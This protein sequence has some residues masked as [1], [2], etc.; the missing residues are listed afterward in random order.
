MEPTRYLVLVHFAARL[1]RENISQVAGNVAASIR[2][3]LGNTEAV[4][5]SDAMVG[6][7]G[8][9]AN[10]PADIFREIAKDLRRGD[11]LSVIELGTRITTSHPGLHSWQE[12][13]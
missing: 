8:T 13:I 12:S 4:I 7:A 3:N 1:T 5:T 11:N 2:L 9:S 6:I 10:E